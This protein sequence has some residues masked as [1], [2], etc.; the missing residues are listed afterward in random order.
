M[1]ITKESLGMAVK[2]T[3]ETV[4][5]FFKDI[6]RPNMEL[7]DIKQITFPRFRKLIKKYEEKGMEYGGGK[8]YVKYL[9]E[10][11]FQ[12]EFEMYFRDEEGSWH[13]IANESGPRDITLLED[14]LI[15]TM[16]SLQV[17]EFPIEAESSE[18]PATTEK[19]AN[20]EKVIEPA[21]EP[22][23]AIS[24]VSLSKETETSDTK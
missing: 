2:T 12:L 11:H 24:E 1:A 21:Q 20:A 15:K 22:V 17:A 8:F 9:D 14:S 13:K 10:G 18:K 4:K 7:E 16:A 23:A 5:D 19:V 6:L 3:V